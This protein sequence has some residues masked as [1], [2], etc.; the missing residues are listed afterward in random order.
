MAVS[1]SI[2]ATRVIEALFPFLRALLNCYGVPEHAQFL[3]SDARILSSQDGQVLSDI[4]QARL[5][6]DSR[7]HTSFLCDPDSALKLRKML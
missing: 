7:V 3:R 1:D 6:A 2:D 5:Q 4:L